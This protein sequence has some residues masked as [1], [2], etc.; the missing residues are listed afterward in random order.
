M[1]GL[2]CTEQQLSL[3]L[4]QCYLYTGQYKKAESAATDVLNLAPRCALALYLKAEAMFQS[5]VSYTFLLE[6]EYIIFIVFRA[7]SMPWLYTIEEGDSHQNAKLE[8]FF[9]E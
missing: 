4:S 1:H 7:M 9:Q 8:S 3:E 6:L 2:P 5:Q